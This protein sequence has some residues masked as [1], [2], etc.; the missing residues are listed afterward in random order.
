MSK[1]SLESHNNVVVLKLNDPERLNAIGVEMCAEMHEALLQIES[2]R[3]S[4]CLLLTGEGRS[5]SSG[6]NLQEAVPDGPMEPASSVL[7]NHY[8]PPLLALKNMSMPVLTAINGPAAG[9]GMSFA[10]LGDLTYASRSAYFIQAF[11][12]V[13]LT[14]DGGATWML[15]RLIGLKKSFELSMQAERL[16]AED[17]LEWGLING[18]CE[19]D[20]LM[21]KTMEIAE[22]LA[23]G[24][25][26]ISLM[27]RLYWSSWNNSFETQIEL[28]GEMQTRATQTRDF[29]EGVRSFIEKRP[30]VFNGE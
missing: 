5:F 6:G 4:R 19:D 14:P 8:H 23:A 2:D 28:E 11:A 26:S 24:P 1:I 20:E 16:S 7:R 3:A 10:L 22:K 27:R 21:E 25:K 9:V 30:A 15:P 18:V 12:K 17:A 29:M 13:G